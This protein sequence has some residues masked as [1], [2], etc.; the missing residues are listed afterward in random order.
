M[1]RSAITSGIYPPDFSNKQ[2]VTGNKATKEVQ[3]MDKI[4]ALI[5]SRYSMSHTPTSWKVEEIFNESV[6]RC[7]VSYKAR[8]LSDEIL[9]KNGWIASSFRSIQ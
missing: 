3:N 8:P 9:R 7:V 2:I 4:Q 5:K 6:F 1:G